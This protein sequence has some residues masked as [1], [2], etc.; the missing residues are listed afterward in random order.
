MTEFYVYCVGEKFI[1]INELKLS[2]T[3]T[4]ENAAYWNSKKNANSWMKSIQKKYPEAILKP[5]I[6]TLK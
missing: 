4:I 5:A 1:H 2:L 3:K 6:L